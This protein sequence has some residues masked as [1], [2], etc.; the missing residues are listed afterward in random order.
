MPTSSHKILSGTVLY[1]D[2]RQFSIPEKVSILDGFRR[3][4]IED[5]QFLPTIR[6]A[7]RLGDLATPDMEETFRASLTDPSRER[8]HQFHVF[9]LITILRHGR[10]PPGLVD[11]MAQ[12]VRDGQWYQG[13]RRDALRVCAREVAPTSSA[14][15]ELDALLADIEAGSVSDPD[16]ELLGTLL[17]RLYPVRL[18]E[19]AILRYLRA[20]KN[21]SLFGNYYTF[22]TV[23]LPENSS[24]KQLATFLDLL[25]ER[26]D[27]LRPVFCGLP[28]TGQPSSPD[29]AHLAAALS[30]N[31]RKR[32]CPRTVS[33]TGSGWHPIPDCG[34]GEKTPGS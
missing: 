26:F 6:R 19:Q 10:A 18:C 14:N 25:V 22:W 28:G 9:C 3:Q 30:S 13:I 1:G 4:A 2:A 27:Q 34:L 8:D 15:A 5:R 32:T 12:I 20:P 31:A 21:P 16:D 7:T 29:A 17:A 23:V 11:L 33:S 24:Q